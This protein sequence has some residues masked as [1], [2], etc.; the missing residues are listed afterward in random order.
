MT[1]PH[2]ASQRVPE[3][4]ASL[5]LGLGGHIALLRPVHQNQRHGPDGSSR[6]GSG[7]APKL[8]AFGA[9]SAV[10]GRIT[11][12]HDSPR[13]RTRLSPGLAFD[14][15]HRA[16]ALGAQ[17]VLPLHGPTPASVS[18]P[19]P[20]ALRGTAIEIT[21]KAS[22]TAPPCRSRHLLDRHQPAAAASRSVRQK[23]ASRPTVGKIED[24]E[25]LLAP[26]P[27]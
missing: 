25:G 2:R 24:V 5:G 7:R 10:R 6:L 9:K 4:L 27:K 26:A 17:H 21:S 8:S 13:P 3:R 18:P 19:G 15:L 12:T 16:V 20:H 14:G 11:Q 23:R 22:G 1:R